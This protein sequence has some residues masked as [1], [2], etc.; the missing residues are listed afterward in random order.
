MGSSLSS[1]LDDCVKRSKTHLGSSAKYAEKLNFEN[2]SII[3]G[4]KTTNPLYYDWNRVFIK[5]CDGS[6]H[7]GTREAP[8]NYKDIN[9]YFRGANNTLKH[10]EY[11]N[12]TYQLFR[13]SKIVLAGYDAGAQAVFYWADYFQ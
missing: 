4:N 1:V 6:L 13:S 11:L 10:F 3:S 7:Q 5:Y 8:V 12:I 2:V 9:L